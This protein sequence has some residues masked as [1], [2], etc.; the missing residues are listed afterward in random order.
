MPG[1]RVDD[2]EAAE[3]FGRE[4]EQDVVE[5]D[6]HWQQTIGAAGLDGFFLPPPLPDE[7][8]EAILLRIPPDDPAGL[9]RQL[10]PRLLLPH[11]PLRATLLPYIPYMNFY[12]P[13]LLIRISTRNLWTR[14]QDEVSEPSTL[15]SKVIKKLGASFCE[16][17]PEVLSHEALSGKK[18][19]VEIIGGS[20]ATGEDK[21]ARDNDNTCKKNNSELRPNE[22]A[23]KRQSSR[24]NGAKTKVLH[25]CPHSALS[26]VKNTVLDSSQ[27]TV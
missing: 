6:V 23:K 12:T 8:V 26:E 11:A 9:I 13:V 18:K 14:I 17:T 22:R 3:L 21:E 16:M 5:H 27:C 24:V 19:P 20:K 10:R 15:F 2:A 1:R 4:A 7:I 25:N